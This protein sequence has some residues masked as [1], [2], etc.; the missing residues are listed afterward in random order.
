MQ[1]SALQVLNHGH[2]SHSKGFQPN[3]KHSQELHIMASNRREVVKIP[4]LGQVGSFGDRIWVEEKQWGSL[5]GS[6]LGISASPRE[7]KEQSWA[8]RDAG[9]WYSLNFGWPYSELWAGTTLQRCPKFWVRARFYIPM[10][11]LGSQLSSAQVISPRDLPAETTT[12]LLAPKE[13]SD[14]S[15]S[16]HP[17]PY[18][19]LSSKLFEFSQP[20]LTLD[21]QLPSF[22]GWV[23]YLWKFLQ[24]PGKETLIKSQTLSSR[25][26]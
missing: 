6:A 17:N 22:V 15:H 8:E 3:P 23:Q 1:S 24:A 19:Q 12:T 26:T 5:L 16:G 4:V 25:C 18:P 13:N 9:L 14:G 2:M 11:I 21:G 10:C 7:I 20:M